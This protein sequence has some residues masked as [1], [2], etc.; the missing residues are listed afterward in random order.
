MAVS[1]RAVVL[2][3]A[4][5]ERYPTLKAR[6]EITLPFNNVKDAFQDDVRCNCPGYDGGWE[7]KLACDGSCDDSI[8]FAKRKAEAIKQTG[9]RWVVSIPFPYVIERLLAGFV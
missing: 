3:L 6:Y 4:E 2:R 1:K 9:K 5:L 8:S 7:Y